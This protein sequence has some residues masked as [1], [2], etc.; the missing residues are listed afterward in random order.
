MTRS[1]AVSVER[2]ARMAA[3]PPSGSEEAAEFL[4]LALQ[5]LNASARDLAGFF[6]ATDRSEEQ[7]LMTGF[8]RG[9]DAA[10]APLRSAESRVGAAA[11]EVEL[12][13]L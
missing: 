12:P 8:R 3:A 4:T 10:E 9:V 6:R 1:T 2:A 13:A 7:R 5:A 11:T